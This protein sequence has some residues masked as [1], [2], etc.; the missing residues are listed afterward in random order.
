MDGAVQRVHAVHA[1]HPQLSEPQLSESSFIRILV[2]FNPQKLVVFHELYNIL[3]DG[4]H[5]VM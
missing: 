1:V 5:L 4:G 2:Y 3:Q